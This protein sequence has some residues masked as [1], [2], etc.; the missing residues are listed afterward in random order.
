VTTTTDFDT[1]RVLMWRRG[2]LVG[3]RVPITASLFV[4][5]STV[6]L[7]EWSEFDGLVLRSIYG[8]KWSKELNI[9]LKTPSLHVI[10]R[11]AEG[12]ETV[13]SPRGDVPIEAASGDGEL[14]LDEEDDESD[15]G[16]DSAESASPDKRS[17]RGRGLNVYVRHLRDVEGL[18]YPAIL[19]AVLAG[20]S[21]RFVRRLKARGDDDVDRLNALR[22]LYAGARAEKSHLEAC[23][24]E[25]CVSQRGNAVTSSAELPA[26]D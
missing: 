4:W 12:G 13:L 3:T 17:Y 1:Y 21:P 25:P 14:E 6:R 9:V 24:Y 20:N 26:S 11:T 7:G 10:G 5:E 15:D 22:E 8:E 2:R 19:Q 23:P 18:Q 16:G